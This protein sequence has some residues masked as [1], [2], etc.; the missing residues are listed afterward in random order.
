MP[1]TIPSLCRLQVP[2]GTNPLSSLVGVTFMSLQPLK[3][4]C[5]SVE[6]Y[7]HRGTVR[8]SYLPN[9]FRGPFLPSVSKCKV[10]CKSLPQPAL[11]IDS[12]TD[13][14]VRYC[15]SICLQFIDD[16]VDDIYR[17]GEIVQFYPISGNQSDTHKS[18]SVLI[19][20]FFAF[21]A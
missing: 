12:Q 10:Y 20:G 11:Q 19:H 21:L 1:T 6:D 13:G 16:I 4:P 8:T 14:Y 7:D 2:T 18:R 5:D 17:S 3:F 9:I 15:P